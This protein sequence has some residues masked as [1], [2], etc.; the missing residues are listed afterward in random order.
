MELICS[1]SVTHIHWNCQHQDLISLY[2]LVCYPFWKVHI[3]RTLNCCLEMYN[4]RATHVSA[5]SLYSDTMRHFTFSPHH[6]HCNYDINQTD[7]LLYEREREEAWTE[8]QTKTKMKTHAGRGWG[9][10]IVSL[11]LSLVGAA[12][13][14]PDHLIQSPVS[15][16]FTAVTYP[17]RVKDNNIGC[18]SQTTSASEQWHISML[19]TCSQYGSTWNCWPDF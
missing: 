18:D 19:F 12:L 2:F 9:F 1:L 14:I 15:N 16:K 11:S 4:A 17:D 10:N 6:D 7:P 13:L 3:L 5:N 8:W